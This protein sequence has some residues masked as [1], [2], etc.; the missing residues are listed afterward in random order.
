MFFGRREV[1][2]AGF[3]T[4][5]VVELDPDFEFEGMDEDEDGIVL[6]STVLFLFSTR[7]VIVSRYFRHIMFGEGLRFGLTKPSL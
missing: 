3:K 6:K 4:Q 1:N 7:S 5:V 2:V